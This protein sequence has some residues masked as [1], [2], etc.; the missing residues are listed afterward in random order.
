MTELTHASSRR[1]LT[2]GLALA[3]LIFTA[4]AQNQ[5]GEPRPPQPAVKLNVLVL[6]DSKHAVDNV[7]QNEFRVFENG[8]E[9]KVS[10]FTK[11]SLP[12]SFGLVVDNSGSLRGEFGAIIDTCKKI[13]SPMRPEDEAFVMRFVSSEKIEILRDF[14]SNKAL[15][16]RS[17]DELFPEGGETALIDAVITAAMHMS[18]SKKDDNRQ[19]RRVL[20]LISDGEDRKSEGN[21][22]K[23]LTLLSKSDIQIYVIGL[24]S[25]LRH[26]PGPF[27][28][29]ATRAD[30]IELLDRLAKETGGRAFYPKSTGQLSEIV[31]DIMRDLDAQYQIG[32]DPAPKS[33]NKAYRSVKVT[34]ERQKGK[35]KRTV[36][37]RPGYLATGN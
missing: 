18:K 27:G 1:A 2:I 7:N 6:D 36:I 23:L 37:T 19:S 31:T 14:T 16:D 13:V 15:L 11:E 5:S 21:A 29:K 30:A 26:R 35:E 10:F 22:E 8:V 33:N 24:V 28:Q 4:T 3:L 17:L 9:Q 25:Q 12:L 34:I 20:F 32:Y